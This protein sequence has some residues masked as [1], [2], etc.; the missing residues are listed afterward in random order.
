MLC[1]VRAEITSAGT[2]TGEDH[3]GAP[4]ALYRPVP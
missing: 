1:Q 4:G 2:V 3:K